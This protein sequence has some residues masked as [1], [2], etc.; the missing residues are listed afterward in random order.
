MTLPSSGALSFG[1]IR[2]E[3]GL[4]NSISSYRGK[5][6]VPASGAIKFSQLYGASA[7]VLVTMVCGD[8]GFGLIGYYSYFAAGSINKQPLA[9]ETLVQY[10]TQFSTI[11][12]AFLGDRRTALAG[13]KFFID[14]VQRTV[15]ITYDSSTTFTTAT[16]TGFSQTWAV[17]Q[18]HT[19]MVS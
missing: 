13:K 14:G 2:T 10:G 5:G 15:S 7:G 12:V 8:S 17:G 6:S 16:V 19:L 4:G 1:A 18:S 11:I 3:F 9:G